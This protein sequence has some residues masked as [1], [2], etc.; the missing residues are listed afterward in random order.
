MKFVISYKKR[1]V[2]FLMV[3]ITVMFVTYLNVFFE[4]PSELT[5]LQGQEYQ[6][7]FKSPFLVCIKPD[8]VGV[9]KVNNGDLNKDGKYLTL[10]NPL[11]I[12]SQ[13]DGTVSLDI[14][15]FGFIPLRTM[16][17]A[18]V[19]NNKIAVSGN[20]IGVKLKINGVL[21]IGISDVDTDIG[22]KELPVRQSGIK[23][24]DIIT[25]INSKRIDTIDELVKTITES[26]GKKINIKFRH[27]EQFKEVEV[28]PVKSI[29]DN[30]YHI[31]LWV[32]ESTAGI[33]TITFFDPESFCFGA[34]GHG[35]TDIDTGSI[36]SIKSGDIMNTT[37]LTVKKGKQ[38]NPGELKGVFVDGKKSLGTISVNCEH[39][40]YGKLNLA[41]LK[42]L[43][44]KLYPIAL[45]DQIKEGNASILSNIN[46]NKVEEFSVD[47]LKISKRSLDGSKGMVIKITDSRLLDATGGIVQGMSGSPII[48]NGKIIGAV[49]H[50]L[51]NDP[52]RGYG[53]FIESMIKNMNIVKQQLTEMSEIAV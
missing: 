25:E 34:L 52:T 26:N 51:V 41:S 37:I 43:T 46:G 20:A 29:Q 5:L 42:N 16:K 23:I 6:Y 1:L 8:K 30:K 22:D 27:G 49:T 32:R 36:M 33:G 47:I 40:I 12:K 24:G 3:C 35:I 11:L 31:G 39:G 17:V 13:K 9:V 50:V 44:F 48:Q 4:I 53:I 28:S 38:G 2:L 18:I 21:I 10:F 45:R 7:N 14:T 15:I 19:P